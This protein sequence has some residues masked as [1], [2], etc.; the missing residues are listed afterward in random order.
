MSAVRISF[1]FFERGGDEVA[2]DR[3][4]D[5]GEDWFGEGIVESCFF[6]Q[7][8]SDMKGLSEILFKIWLEESK[9]KICANECPK[10]IRATENERYGEYNFE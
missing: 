10:R 5:A 1:C 6:G 2:F 9:Y 8:N 4:R 3:V 7:G